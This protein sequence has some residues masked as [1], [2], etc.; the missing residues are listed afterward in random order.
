[1]TNFEFHDK[2]NFKMKSQIPAAKFIKPFSRGQITLPKD[3][4]DYL[5]IDENSW[6]KIFLLRNQIIVE[7]VEE[8]EKGRVVKP[9]V[10]RET[11]LRILKRIKGDWFDEREIKRI[12]KEIEERLAENEK[13]L[14]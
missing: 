5:D 8:I 14:A 6:L 1:M 2:L 3:Y 4:R 11:Y 9:S 13:S 12:R 7:P 10:D